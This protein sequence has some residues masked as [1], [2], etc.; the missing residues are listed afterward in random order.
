MGK[1]DAAGHGQGG[2][3]DIHEM[4]QQAH[5][6]GIEGSSKMDESELREALKRIGKGNDPMMAKQ[7][8][9]RNM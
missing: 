9:K 6:M 2:M 5:D 8:A 4:R 1:Q 3:M 7:E